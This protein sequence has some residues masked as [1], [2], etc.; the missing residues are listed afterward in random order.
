MNTLI[1]TFY[2]LAGWLLCLGVI[3]ACFTGAYR[4]EKNAIKI[5]GFILSCILVPVIFSS[6]P[7]KD[8]I[9]RTTAAADSAD[10][11]KEAQA[12]IASEDQKMQ[13]LCTTTEYTCIKLTAGQNRIDNV[14]KGSKIILSKADCAYMEYVINGSTINACKIISE[15]TNDAGSI[16][17]NLRSDI[18]GKQPVIAISFPSTGGNWWLGVAAVIGIIAIGLVLNANEVDLLNVTIALVAV[19]VIGGLLY[20]LFS[21]W[22]LIIGFIGYSLAIIFLIFAV[23][24]FLYMKFSRD[25]DSGYE[26]YGSSGSPGA[27]PSAPARRYKKPKPRDT[28]TSKG[29]LINFKSG[30]SVFRR[31]RK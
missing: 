25:A 20:L 28:V 1:A 21:Y 4:A 23:G 6:A 22:N 26:E 29:V 5:G 3:A 24:Y 11:I 8:Y 15:K 17:I 31:F 10:A 14:G 19:C 9:S 2:Y 27:S 7:D 18:G 16:V 30:K 13:K 12:L